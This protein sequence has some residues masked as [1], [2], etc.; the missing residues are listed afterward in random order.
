MGLFNLFSENLDFAVV[1]MLFKLQTLKLS[2]L[3]AAP[4]VSRWSGGSR[5]GKGERVRGLSESERERQREK[6]AEAKA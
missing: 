2:A 3:A 6:A 5:S 1:R 4:R